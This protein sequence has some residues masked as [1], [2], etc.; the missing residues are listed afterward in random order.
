MPE[1]GP[2]PPKLSPSAERMVRQVK[3]TQE[4]M[5]RGRNHSSAVLRSIAVLGVI[6]WSVVVPTLAGIAAGAW[7]DRHW[8]SR[9]SWTLVL[10]MT[11]LVLGCAN[12]WLRIRRDQP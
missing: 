4:R 5:A 12:A 10:M 2:T 1:R 6:G 3:A 8:P 11:G 9:F 7:I